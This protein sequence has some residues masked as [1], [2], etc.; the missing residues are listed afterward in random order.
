M[1]IDA[2]GLLAEEQLG[3]VALLPDQDRHAVRRGDRD[4]VE[5]QRLDRQPERTQRP[6]QQQERDHDD[7][8]HDP[9][10]VAVDRETKSASSAAL[11]PTRPRRQPCG[12]VR[13]RPC[14]AALAGS[15]AVDLQQLPVAVSPRFAVRGGHGGDAARRAR[16]A[17]APLAVAAR[18]STGRSTPPGTPASTAAVTA[19]EAG[20]SD[21][22]PD[23][24]GEPE[25]QPQRRERQ[26][27]QHERCDR[28]GEP[29]V[30][31]DGLAMPAQA[32]LRSCGRRRRGHFSR[33]PAALEQRGH[34]GHAT[35][36]R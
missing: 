13:G 27:E 7:R 9:D 5:H 16:T 6:G 31:D 18:T 25:R 11:P 3:A 15:S 34:Q 8:Q 17:A 30:P 35:W 23:S 2:G 19:R 12:P 22:M 14:P 20:E 24:W 36:P 10:R 32:R 1:V 4:D 21:V 29:P 28:D 33:G 26:C